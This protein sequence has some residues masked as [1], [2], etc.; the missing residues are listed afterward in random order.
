MK[1]SASTGKGTFGF[2]FFVGNDAGRTGKKRV[3]REPYPALINQRDLVGQ[4]VVCVVLPTKKY[5][6]QVQV[7]ISAS[8]RLYRKPRQQPVLW[9]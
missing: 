7:P 8:S 9:L 6:L 5:L 3:W 2:S 4:G 1:C